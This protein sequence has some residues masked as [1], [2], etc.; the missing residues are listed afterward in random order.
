[1]IMAYLTQILHNWWL[2]SSLSHWYSNY[3]ISKH[4]IQT[5]RYQLN[6]KKITLA[7]LMHRRYKKKPPYSKEDDRP[8]I[9]PTSGT[10][11]TS[12]HYRST[13]S[14]K[15]HHYHR[16]HMP[17]GGKAHHYMSADG[18]LCTFQVFSPDALTITLTIQTRSP[19]QVALH[20]NQKRNYHLPGTEVGIILSPRA[21]ITLQS[22][23][24]LTLFPKE[25]TEISCLQV[26]GT[27]PTKA[28]CP[29]PTL[30]VPT[31]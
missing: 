24:P 10:V 31:V 3:L 13:I 14:V 2:N 12:S 22:N 28:F 15:M 7:Q 9:M 1:M 25:K 29:T 8:I 19:H 6:N 5:D 26:I 20:Y 21:T 18:T 11:N 30:K 16:I 23:I 4:H 27:A 17:I